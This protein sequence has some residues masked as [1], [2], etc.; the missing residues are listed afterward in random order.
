VEQETAQANLPEI[1]GTGL[2]SP[3]DAAS[4]LT[5][6]KGLPPILNDEQFEQVKA[7]ARAPLPSPARIGDKAFEQ[8]VLMMAAS[9]ARR[10]TDVEVG[11]VQIRVYRRCLAHLSA[12]QMWWT[13]EEAI[14]R[15]KFF[16]TVKELLDIAEGWER[17]DD[18]TEA[19]RLARLLANR[20]NNRRLVAQKRKAPAPALTEEAIAAMTPELRSMGL[21]L[22]HLIEVDGKVIANPE[23]EGTEA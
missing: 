12:P 16:P 2:L 10:T 1:Q 6:L 8:A 7:I 5:M 3:S 18:A 9:L 23:P 21:R 17:R 11:E 22:G 13:V 20:E 15:L 19:H 4:T 14:K